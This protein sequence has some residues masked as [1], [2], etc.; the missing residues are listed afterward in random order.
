MKTCCFRWG[1]RAVGGGSPV[2][3]TGAAR[4]NE[5]NGIDI[6]T[7]TGADSACGLSTDF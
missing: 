1:F 5:T 3:A 2:D 4:R 7:Q 6:C